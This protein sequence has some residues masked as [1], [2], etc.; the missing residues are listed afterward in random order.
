MA[1]PGLHGRDRRG[2]GPWGVCEEMDVTPTPPKFYLP[3]PAGPP[4]RGT[5]LHPL[6]PPVNSRDTTPST[7]RH[8][9]LPCNYSRVDG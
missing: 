5:R 9:K 4:T 6:P 2:V 7:K 3:K 1:G 8:E